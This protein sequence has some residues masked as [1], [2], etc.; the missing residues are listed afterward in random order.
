M[1]LIYH[2]DVL[3]MTEER[4]ISCEGSSSTTRSSTVMAIKLP[5]TWILQAYSPTPWK[6]LG[7]NG[8]TITPESS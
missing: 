2:Y 3:T 7:Y 8:D 1:F 6:V 4:Q 5:D